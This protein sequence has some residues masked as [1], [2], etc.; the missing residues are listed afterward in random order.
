MVLGIVVGLEAE[1][2]VARGWGLPV[3][4]GGGG[5]A[6]AA[7]AAAALAPRVQGLIS[8]GLAGGLDPGLRAGALLVPDCVV[9]GAAAWTV[10]P[11]LATWLGG[12]T[13]H[14]L[15]GGGAVL[16]SA[17]AKRAA[18]AATGADAV[19]LES[20][21]VAR[22]AARHGIPFAALRAVCDEAGQDLPRAALVALDAKG[23]IGAARVLGAVLARPWELGALLRLARDAARA[24]AALLRRVRATE[25]GALS[26]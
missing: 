20:A 11:A 2:R 14:R 18:R 8:F 16:A 12:G 1:A 3:A 23:R 15:L 22:M 10:D 24:R 9:E 19:D 6:G 17:T 5:A 4:V 25:P 21:A 7:A 26:G 13:G